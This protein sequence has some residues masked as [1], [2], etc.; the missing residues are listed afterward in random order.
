MK[1]SLLI[2]LSAVLAVGAAGDPTGEPKFEYPGPEN[3]HEVDA[4]CWLG[5]CGC[6]GVRLDRIGLPV[7]RIRNRT[8][9]EGGNLHNMFVIRPSDPQHG[10]RARDQYV[11]GRD[12]PL[13]TLSTLSVHELKQRLDHRG[14]PTSRASRSSGRGSERVAGGVSYL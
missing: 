9:G 12:A 14:P 10:F 3:R 2:G 8:P 13:V 11:S 5:R 6:S 4:S 7:L 1:T